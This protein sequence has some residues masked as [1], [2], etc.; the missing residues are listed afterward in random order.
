MLKKT[1]ILALVG[2]GRNPKFSPDKL[3]IWDDH[4]NKIFSELRFC[5]DVLRMKLKMDKIIVATK[6]NQLYVLN[7]SNLEIVSIFQTYENKKGLFAISSDDNIFVI[8]FPYRHEGYVKVKNYDSPLNVPAINA[9]DTNVS[10]IT[11]NHEGTLLSTSSEKGTLIRIFSVSNGELIQELRRGA[12]AANIYNI[13][14]DFNNKFIACSSSSGTIHIFSIYTSIKYLKEKGLIPDKSGN[15]RSGNNEID[16]NINNNRVIEEPKNQKGFF[17][18]IISV[19][20]FGISYYESEW[21]FAQFRVPESD[22]EMK[23]NFGQNNT[24]IVLTKKGHL[25][26]ASFEP[27]LGGEC[28]KTNEK[29]SYKRNEKG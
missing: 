28:E 2:T 20:K 18:S 23:V 8:A 10:F 12:K 7:I 13:T 15:G 3:I 1:N 25:F 5:S 16:I 24:I 27:G 9:H 11:I 17:G 6:D 21:S 4:R 19:L 26:Q 22:K 29:K 14:F